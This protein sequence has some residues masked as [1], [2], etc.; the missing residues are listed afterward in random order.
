M[1]RNPKSRLLLLLYEVVESKM[2]RD[3]ETELNLQ[4]REARLENKYHL[5]QNYNNDLIRRSLKS[6][7]NQNR[8]NIKEHKANMHFENITKKLRRKIGKK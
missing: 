3:K 5:V 8:L 2:T 4:M 1:T 7:N 6:Q